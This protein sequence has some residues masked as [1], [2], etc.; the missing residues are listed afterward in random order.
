MAVPT[1]L[2]A[3]FYLWLAASVVILVHRLVTKRRLRT[4]VARSTD[5]DRTSRTD[6]APPPTGSSAA[7]PDPRGTTSPSVPVETPEPA[8]DQPATTGHGG[9]DVPATTLMQALAGIVMPCDLLPLTTV[10]GRVLGDR[11]LLL[12]TSGQPAGEVSEAFAG[13]LEALGYAITPM[14]PVTALATRGPDDITVV[15]H[16]RPFDELSGKRPAFPTTKP[17]DVVLELRL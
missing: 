4:P 8:R 2:V 6:W 12:M 5:T 10:E 3:L 16:E 7:T 1:P 17:G 9:V 15:L 14:G 13:A 11:E